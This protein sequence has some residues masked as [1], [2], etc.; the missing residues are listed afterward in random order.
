SCQ[1]ATPS[2]QAIS[3]QCIAQGVLEGP[4]PGLEVLPLIQ[5]LTVDGLSHLLRAGGTHAALGFVELDA[6]RLEFEAAEIENS[7]HVAF[8]VVDH[9]LVAYSQ[10]SSRKHGIPVPHQLEIRPIVARDVVD[11]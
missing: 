10:D 9:V 8:E 7:P 6:G 2:L 11:A 1:R 3:D 5:A 4:E